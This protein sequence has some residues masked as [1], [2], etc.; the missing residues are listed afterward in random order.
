[1]SYPMLTEEQELMR[2]AARE[3]AEKEGVPALLAQMQAGKYPYDF[4]LGLWPRLAELNFIGIATPEEMGGLGMDVTT[5]LLVM[6][7]LSIAGPIGTNIDAHNLTLHTIEYNGSDFQKQKYGIPAAKGEIICAAAVTDPAGS[8]NFPEWSI[9]VDETEDGYILN[10]TKVFCSSSIA[11]DL[12]AVYTKDY[13]NGYPMGCFLVE[14]DTEGLEYGHLEEFGKTGTNT[15]TVVLKNVKVPKENKI[16]SA[17]LANAAWLG[18]G[19]LDCSAVLIS[20]AQSVLT[21]TTSYVKQRTRNGRPLSAMQAVAHRIAN[22]DMQLE[23]AR[24]LM[25]TAAAFWDAGKPNPKLNSMAK[26]ASSEALTLISH[27][28]VVLHGA[29]GCAPETGVIQ[30]HTVAPTGHVGEC[31]NDFH[32]DLIA[33]EHGIILDSHLA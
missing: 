2:Q 24:C 17:D 9:K 16:P 18:L 4:A 13:E 10:G 20:L 33:R 6:E 26:I 1:M 12:Y 27:D 29:Y 28:C 31:P 25:Y 5:Q 23:Q 7:E 11:A 30:I 21:K 15:G 8:M 3:F 32:R 14:K 19:Y 22:M